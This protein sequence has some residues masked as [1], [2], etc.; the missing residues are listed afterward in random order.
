MVNI[1]NS[2]IIQIVNYLVMIA[3]LNFVL[4][5]PIRGIIK[6]RK[7][8]IESFQSDIDGLTTKTRERLK[9][10]EDRLVEARREGF[11]QKDELK[12]KGLE[13]EKKILDAA[14]SEA[15]SAIRKIQEQVKGEIA[16]ARDALRKDL[17]AFS[18]EL[19]Q[20]VLGRS[21]T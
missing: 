3:L 12:S 20:K 18:K 13:E 21:L 9:E 7:E 15:E 17:E 8:R 11:A 2:L 4:Y 6:Q 14:G 1:D 5:K 16:S 19:A 10:M